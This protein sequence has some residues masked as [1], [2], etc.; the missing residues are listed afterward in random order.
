MPVG[1]GI[2]DRGKERTMR[3]RLLVVAG[4]ILTVLAPAQSSRAESDAPSCFDAKHG[5]AFTA[6]KWLTSPG[7]LTGTA[8]NDVLVGTTGRDKIDG[9]GGHDLICS[10]P[11]GGEFG[12]PDSVDGG[13]GNDRIFGVGR[14]RGGLDNDYIEVYFV[15]S[16]GDGGSGNDVVYASVG[17]S[18]YGGAG[19]DEV[20]VSGPGRADGG[21]GNDVVRGNDA[22]SLL[23]GSGNDGITNELGDPLI[24][25]GSGRDTVF[26]ADA[27]S[28]SA[29]S[30]AAKNAHPSIVGNRAK[31]PREAV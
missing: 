12:S 15:G 10:A 21:S 6:T 29:T 24:N 5:E 31:K 30:D 25:C 18:A 3:V 8:G 9:K 17:A 28:D 20:I 14:L 11:A 13:P 1:A 19:S 23:G 7:S 27:A 4:L 26:A 22:E 16:H 2:A